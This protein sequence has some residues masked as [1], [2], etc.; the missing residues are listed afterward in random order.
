MSNGRVIVPE[1]ESER[2]R[3]RDWR[4]DDLA[5]FA[6]IVADPEVMRFV[7]EPLSG[8]QAAA[9]IQRFRG[10]WSRFGFGI[11]AVQERSSGAL[12][13]R[14]GLLHH[15]D[16]P[17]PDNVEVGW[18]LA[19]AAWGRGLA[20]EAGREALRFGFRRCN[21]DRIISITRPT[22]DRSIRVMERLWLR[23]GGETEWRGHHV[24]WYRASR[25]KW[26]T[27]DLEGPGP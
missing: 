25:E 18:I 11:W 15:D 8:D 24:V 26:L 23:L 5:A 6:A 22:N 2:L 13:G 1:L 7:R 14:V 21:L 3:L 10:H 4:D 12:L 20:T 9:E 27:A 19:R 17:G 16:W